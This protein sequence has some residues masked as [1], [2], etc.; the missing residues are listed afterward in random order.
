MK[1]VYCAVNS[2]VFC[3]KRWAIPGMGINYRREGVQT[4]LV[5]GTLQCLLSLHL[6]MSHS[7]T[8]LDVWWTPG[9]QNILKPPLKLL[10]LSRGVGSWNASL[11]KAGA[12][13]A[14]LAWCFLGQLGELSV[15]FIWHCTGGVFVPTQLKQHCRYQE[16]LLSWQENYKQEMT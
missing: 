16:S 1:K 2:H 3:G 7:L 6:D 13:W 15:V 11:W 10:L 12:G 9:M 14:Q 4:A 5:V 8:F